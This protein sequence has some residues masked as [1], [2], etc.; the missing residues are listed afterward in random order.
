MART[1]GAAALLIA[2]VGVAW[3][4]D[5]APGPARATANYV[6]P[7][8][9]WKPDANFYRQWTTNP[10]LSPYTVQKFQ[11]VMPS[12][13]PLATYPPNKPI[14]PYTSSNPRSLDWPK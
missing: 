14:K 11:P 6:A 12:V 13:T 1:I 10:N 2:M 3:A 5:N 4:D 9:Q 8:Y 7:Q